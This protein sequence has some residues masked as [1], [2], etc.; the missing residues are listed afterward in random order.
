MAQ[1]TGSF[2]SELSR[3]KRDPEYVAQPAARSEKVCKS[4]LDGPLGYEKNLMSFTSC[5]ASTFAV[6]HASRGSDRFPHS[7]SRWHSE[8]AFRVSSGCSQSSVDHEHSRSALNDEDLSELI[9]LSISFGGKRWSWYFCLSSVR[10][11][12]PPAAWGG[13][14]ILGTPMNWPGS[15]LQCAYSLSE[16][17]H[18][19]N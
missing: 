12:R 16:I 19:F 18:G 11:G 3:V 1:V 4:V 7:G 8:M 9:D 6:H 2:G 5:R 13:I 14:Q 17:D 10:D 15:V